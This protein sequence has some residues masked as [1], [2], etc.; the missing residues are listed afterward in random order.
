MK[1]WEHDGSGLQNQGL[2][3]PVSASPTENWGLRTCYQ[4][5]LLNCA[6]YIR[7]RVDLGVA[8]ISTAPMARSTENPGCFKDGCWKKQHSPASSTIFAV[9]RASTNFG[10]SNGNLGLD[11]LLPSSAYKMYHLH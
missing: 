11:F 1:V 7:P 5:L 8:L 6:I 2:G 3:P 10:V 9:L 4:I